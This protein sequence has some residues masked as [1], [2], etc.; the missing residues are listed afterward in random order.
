MIGRKELNGID[1]QQLIDL[2][3]GELTGAEAEKLRAEII[4]KDPALAARVAA[5]QRDRQMLRNLPPVDPPMDFLAELEPMIARPMLMEEINNVSAADVD[6]PVVITKPGAARRAV[7]REHRRA[8]LIPAAIAAG[9]VIVLAGGLWFTLTQVGLFDKGP[10]LAVNGDDANSERLAVNNG[11]SIDNNSPAVVSTGEATE[12]LLAS[13]ELHHKLPPVGEWSTGAAHRVAIAGND[14][15][16]AN[17]QPALFLVNPQFVL[18][19]FQLEVHA[20]KEDAPNV[21]ARAIE[22][23]PGRAAVVRNLTSENLKRIEAVWFAS[24][25]EARDANEPL[26]ANVNNTN[27]PAGNPRV[28]SSAN[29]TPALNADML[30]ESADKLIESGLVA[31]EPKLM[32]GY[33][34]QIELSESG[35]VYTIVLPVSELQVMLER[36]ASVRGVQ[37]AML[38]MRGDAEDESANVDSTNRWVKDLSRVKQSWEALA[39]EHPDAVVVLPIVVGGR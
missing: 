7:H 18:A 1:E 16:P 30:R 21:L 23:L 10:G 34:T 33:D 17:D 13:G 28:N 26:R 14:T 9:V 5:M 38:V 6:G 36:L 12:E 31:G 19:D 2:I 15:K 35:S 37:S 8:Q 39:A 3:E 4:R 22:P 25:A 20:N 29:K 11:N 32:P 27:M 24:R